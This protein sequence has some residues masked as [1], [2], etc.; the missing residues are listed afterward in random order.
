METIKEI[1]SLI[2]SLFGIILVLFLT[3]YCT[4]WLSQKSNFVGKSQYIKIVDKVVLGQNQY[5]T[6]V[7]VGGKYLLLGVSDKN[8]NVIKE[9][10]DFIEKPSDYNNE[11]I[12]FKRVFSKIM[13]NKHNQ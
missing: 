10:E 8:I 12:D 11:S 13:K 1:F 3:Y 2:M 7:E 9:F 6:I 5:L 4:K